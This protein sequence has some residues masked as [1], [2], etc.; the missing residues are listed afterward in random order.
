MAPQ[1]DTGPD[2]YKVRGQTFLARHNR[3]KSCSIKLKQ[4]VFLFH[5]IALFTTFA[6]LIL[7]TVPTLSNAA[8]PKQTHIQSACEYDYPPFCVVEE[9]GRANGFSVELLRAALKATE[10]NVDFRVGPWTEV[11]GLLE[12]GEIDVLPLVGRTPEREEVFD[13]T[14]PYLSLHGV[15]VVPM[16]TTNIHDLDDLAGK[17]VAVMKGD[18]AEEFLR[19]TD[20]DVSLQTTETFETALRELSQGKHDAVVIQRLLALRLLQQ[21]GIKNLKLIEKPLEGLQQDFCFAVKEGDK[22]ALSILNEGLSLVMADGTFSRLQSKWFA[23]LELPQDN[24]IVVGGDHNYP[25][26]EFLDKQGQPAGYNVELT[27]AIGKA[28]GLDIEI[29]LGPWAEVKEGLANGDIQAIQG[30]FYSPEREREFGFSPPH[31]IIHHVAVVREGV[32]KM[33]LG[34]EDLDTKRIVVMQDDIMHDWILKNAPGAQVSTVESQSIALQEL[35]NGQHDLALMARLPALFL[36]EKHGLENLQIAEESIL[37]PEYC[38]AVQHNQ[39]I[40]LAKLTE[41]MKVLHDSGEY[42]QIHSKW[43]GIYDPPA[44]DL[45]TILRYILFTVGPLLLLISLFW[46]RTLRKQVH[47]RTKELQESEERFKGMFN[48]MS[49][50]VAVYESV[51]NGKDFVFIDLNPAGERIDQ[52]RRDEVIGK[53]VTE[54]FPGVTDYGVLHSFRRVWNTG[55]AEKQPAAIYRDERVQGWR[56]GF[57]YKLPTGEI[58]S[59]YDDISKRHEAEAERER[60]RHFLQTVIDGVPDSLMVINLDYTIALANH[61]TLRMAGQDPVAAKLTCH[62]VSHGSAT[63]CNSAEHICPLKKVIETKAPVTV[64]HI[65]FDNLGHKTNVELVA[66]PI[67]DEN[68]EVHQIIELCRDVTERKMREETIAAQLQLSESVADSSVDELLTSFLD[69]AE[70]LTRSQIG[71]FHFIEKDQET[72]RLQTWSTNTLEKLCTAEGVG[73]HYSID[74]AGVWVDCV[75]E[76]KPVV[77]NDYASLPHRQGLPEGHAPVTRELVVPIHR[78]EQMVAI[79]GVGNKESD[80]TEQDVQSILNLA[81]MAWDI[82][83]RKQAEVEREKLETQLRHSQKMDALGQ[84]AGGVAHDFNNLLHAILGYGDIALERA[85]KE[86]LFRAPVEEMIN[87]ANRAKTLVKQ[88]LAFSHRQVLDMKDVDL[89]LV[90]KDFTKM[91]QRVIGSHITLEINAAE[92]LGIVRADPGQIDQI[93]MNL[94]VNAND[95]M[96]EGGTITIKTE[97]IQIDEEYCE[98]HSWAKTGDFVLLSVTDQGCGMDEQTITNAFEPFFTTKSL[99]KGTGLGLSMVYGLVTQ[100]QGM[101]QIE[102]EIAVGTKVEIY[103][104]T[105]HGSSIVSSHSLAAFA[106]G[107]TETILIAEDEPALRN[108]TRI[109]LENAGYTVLLAADGQEAIDI[110]TEDHGKVDLAILDVMMPKLGGVAVYKHI[111]QTQPNTKVIFSSGYNMEAIHTNF[112]LEEGLILVQKPFQKNDLLRA[113]RSILEKK[114]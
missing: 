97:N 104:P 4:K 33:P 88:L 90:I 1:D 52:I 61:T 16:E 99:G 93:L 39:K 100:H 53:R 24:R 22:E 66:A 102:S 60:S 7:C 34:A 44:P 54:V 20:I 31:T 59:I 64:E 9:G 98:T 13:F 76:G 70:E 11:K 109:L 77:H 92:G 18:N 36:I 103:L 51:D 68:G 63:V 87:A 105:S 42:Q 108:L 107:G 80:Y 10:R 14:F 74:K 62:Q 45:T 95:A 111:L 110:L 84:L 30:M 26:Y 35:A 57:V 17:S 41:G 6:A 114:R 73:E 72:L 56:E 89:N 106:S 112:V 113:V 47:S 23:A 55:E 79:L 94:C 19:R 65:H 28:T 86:K 43:M 29:R 48:Y 5:Q 78:G 37:A 91:I 82:V 40:L 96:P 21:T 71:F 32:V 85:E 46:S 2:A 83:T 67:F 27:R 81:N 50:G 69:K 25:P 12:N 75:R 38:Y 58:V 3:E 49:N 15:I 101:V 8:I